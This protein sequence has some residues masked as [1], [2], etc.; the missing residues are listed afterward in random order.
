MLMRRRRKNIKQ[1][2]SL[3]FIFTVPLS[4]PHMT[5]QDTIL[6]GY[7]VP[8]DTALF[9]NIYSAS[10]DPK[11]W[12]EPER[13]KP[14]RFLTEAGKLNTVDAWIPFSAGRAL[15]YKPLS[16]CCVS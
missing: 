9:P 7:T 6:S 3:N 8:K 16:F 15:F 1:Q 5:T 11:H 14:E 13:F 4:V 12:D 2:K 10:F